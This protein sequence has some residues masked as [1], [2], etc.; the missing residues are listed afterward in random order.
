MGEGGKEGAMRKKR[1][2]KEKRFIMCIVTWF[3]RSVITSVALSDK[4]CHV[5]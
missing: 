4:D 1:R 2:E 3:S 5:E